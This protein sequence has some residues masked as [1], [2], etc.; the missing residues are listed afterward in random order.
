MQP[1]SGALAEVRIEEAL[2]AAQGG[3]VAAFNTLVLVYQ[4]QMFNVCYRTLG[5][6]D[7]AA[8]AT[9]DALLSA[10]RG[11]KSF[12][13]AAGGLRGWLLR[14]AVNTCYDQLRRRQRRPVDSLDAP[15]QADPD[16]P[17]S[18]GDHL[19]DPGLGP[20]QRSLTAET[21]R[22]IQAALDQLPP[23]QRLTVVLCDVQ[24][25][26][27]DEAAQAMAVELGTVKSRLSRARAQLRELLIAK[28][29]LPTASQRLQE[30]NP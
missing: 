19:P 25:L 4:R 30:R 1:D 10:F 11:L 23:D 24:G 26:S 3:D 22:H 29:E 21:A 7:D 28:G 20:E 18:L 27:Y 2:R 17:S 15:S 5:S 12:Q 6:T 8:D 9:Q 13:G 16:Q 14:I